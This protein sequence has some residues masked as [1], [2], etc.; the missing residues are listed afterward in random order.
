MHCEI[1]CELDKICSSPKHS[2]LRPV[3]LPGYGTSASKVE[4]TLISKGD[5]ELDTNKAPIHNNIKCNV[6]HPGCQLN[7]RCLN[8]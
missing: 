1:L 2:P 3:E 8:R 4:Y 6:I 5:G 7:Q